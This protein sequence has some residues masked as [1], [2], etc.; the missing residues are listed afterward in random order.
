METYVVS[1]HSTKILRFGRQTLKLV[2]SSD[3]ENLKSDFVVKP[4][5]FLF[6]FQ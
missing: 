6:P 1:S 4:V 2:F 3:S 5:I